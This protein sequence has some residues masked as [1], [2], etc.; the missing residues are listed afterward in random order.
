MNA[1]AEKTLPTLSTREPAESQSLA[2]FVL[3]VFGFSFWFLMA[4]PFACHR[5]TYDWLAMVY[6]QG[7]S[8][9]FSFS[10]TTFRP[11]SQAATWLAFQFLNPAV[12]PTSV[13]RQ[14]LFQFFIYGT[15]VVGWWFIFLRVRE[16]RLFAL[17]SFLAGGAF[18]SGYVHLFHIY[19]LFYIPVML[20]VGGLIYF[21]RP[22]K[23]DRREAGFG[24]LAILLVFWHP[25]AS[26]LF[27]GFYFGHYIETFQRR[28]KLQHIQAL[29][30]LAL[31]AAAIGAMVIS[32]S[33]TQTMPL[34]TRAL[35]FL[36]SY[37]TNEVNR[38][39]SLVAY[40]LAQVV[41][42]SMDASRGLKIAGVFVVTV[43][44]VV[45]FLKGLPLLF[46]WLCAVLIKLIHLRS[47]SLFFLSLV[48]ILLP[49]GGGIGTPIYALFAIILAVYVSPLGWA[50]AEKRLSIF[51]TQY[52]LAVIA[53]LGIVLLLVR[54]NVQVPIVTRAATPLLTERERT[55]QLENLLA[56]LHTSEYC[57]Y[58]IAFVAD[59]GSPVDSVESAITRRN[60]PPAALKDVRHYWNTVLQ[61]QKGGSPINSPETV[62][63]T[64]G[65]PELAAWNPVFTVKGRYA[66]D[67]TVWVR[68]PQK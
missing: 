61:C 64:F 23:V 1:T 62:V 15:F 67:A 49:F 2:F 38:I 60:R 20:T 37:Q 43:A 34:D 17:I 44:S 54:A 55:Y 11:L 24:I 32:S 7:F 46:V 5:E 8:G 41:V 66:G 16:R 31:T 30:I 29:A 51:K 53:V 52:A 9:A 21:S 28:N 48:A 19:G 42:L 45:F 63:L 4:V 35:G 65:G 50:Q 18:F 47:W 56:W 68:S 13:L 10:A 36:V 26:A 6:S 14:A 40:V 22:I 27:L 12:F 39:A 25:Y 3:A 59:A 58:E 57:G 33:R